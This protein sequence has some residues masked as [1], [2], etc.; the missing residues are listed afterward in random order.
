[1]K[2][3]K[4]HTDLHGNSIETVLMELNQDAYIEDVLEAFTRFLRAVGYHFDGNIEIVEQEDF[5]SLNDGQDWGLD[6]VDT[7]EFEGPIEG[8]NDGVNVD[9]LST[10]LPSGWPFPEKSKP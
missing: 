4:T 1:M 9:E 2:F 8:F 3:S 5:D 7:P 6:E 10:D